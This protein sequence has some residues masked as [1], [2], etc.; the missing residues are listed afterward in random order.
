MAANFGVPQSVVS[1]LY[2]RYQQTGEVVEMRGRGRTRAT[3]RADDR[4]VVMESLRSTT[5]SAPKL[6]PELRNTRG[7]N[8]IVQTIRNRLYERG[9]SARRPVIATLLTRRHR[10]TREQWSRAHLRWAQ[11]QWST[12]LFTDESVFRLSCADGRTRVWRRK[13]ERFADCNIIERDPY[14]GGSVMVWA[15]IS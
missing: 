2:Q 1:R 13:I 14:G 6:H 11:R 15:G 4:H 12:V 10:Q 9:I 3:S 5:L 8:V 7:V